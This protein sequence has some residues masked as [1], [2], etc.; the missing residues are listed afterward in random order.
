MLTS[1]QAD[2][3]IDYIETLESKSYHETAMRALNRLGYTE[4]ELD[5]ACRALGKI[6]GRDFS[7]L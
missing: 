6:A 1:E 5:D 2:A 3:L 4:K 7:I